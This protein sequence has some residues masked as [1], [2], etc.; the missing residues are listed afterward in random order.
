[1]FGNRCVDLDNTA[2]IL[3]TER[4]QPCRQFRSPRGITRAIGAV[5][6]FMYGQDGDER[7]RLRP[8]EGLDS[9]F[10][11]VAHKLRHDVRVEEHAHRRAR[12]LRCELAKGSPLR[13]FREGSSMSSPRGALS[14]SHG[15]SPEPCSASHS[16]ADTTTH[17]SSVMPMRWGSPARARRSTSDNCAF[18]L[19][20]VQGL[21]MWSSVD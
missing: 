14:T 7:I 6:Y 21:L 19:C 11:L 20:T 17:A 18:A 2:R 16:L 5:R 8:H 13:D 10:W 1:M 15:P 4:S 3:A 9:R 12:R